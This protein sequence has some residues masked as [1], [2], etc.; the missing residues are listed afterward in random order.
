ME[1]ILKRFPVIEMAREPAR[2]H[3][4]FVKGYETLPVVIPR[5]NAT[6]QQ[7]RLGSGLN[8]F[9]AMV[10]HGDQRL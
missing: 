1:E 8:S 9:D 2:T 5:R 6:T 4:I 10:F 3:S 7:G